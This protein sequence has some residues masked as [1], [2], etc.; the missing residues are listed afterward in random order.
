[1]KYIIVGRSG[2]G[3]TAMMQALTQRGLKPLYTHTTRPSRGPDDIGHVF[4]TD[5]DAALIP[6]ENK[7]C[8]TTFDGYLYFTTK[9]AL[10]DAD[11]MVLEPSGVWE[12]LNAMP[13]ETFN[14]VHMKACDQALRVQMAV[15]R[16][17]GDPATATTRFTAR[18]K[19]EDAVFN[20]FEATLDGLRAAGKSA[21]PNANVVITVDN[22]FVDQT[23][24]DWAAY[25]A[26]QFVTV[27]N[28]KTIVEQAVDLGILTANDAGLIQ[29]VDV[30]GNDMFVNMG[31]FIEIIMHDADNCHALFMSWLTHNLN[32]GVP[33]ELLTEAGNDGDEVTSGQTSLSD[34]L[35]AFP[36]AEEQGQAPADEPAASET[37]DTTGEATTT[38]T[39]T[40]S[41]APE[42]IPAS[43]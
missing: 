6:G 31:H 11:M 35:P 3:K 29:I 24:N 9:E 40:G 18:M 36:A 41:A 8:A 28:L 27:R 39:E 15:A 43:T 2:T 10:A 42:N 12:V 20:Q 23:V 1:M 22:D 33:E 19:N 21:A 37:T 26:G 4:I 5:A 32:I 38:G 34:E 25:L 7:L 30:D 14:I 17:G 16:M 13:D